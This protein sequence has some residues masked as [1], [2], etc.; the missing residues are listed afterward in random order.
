MGFVSRVAAGDYNHVRQP[1]VDNIVDST[2]SVER[3]VVNDLIKSTKLPDPLEPKSDFLPEKIAVVISWCMSM[4]SN[5]RQF[6][7][8]CCACLA[9]SQKEIPIKTKNDKLTHN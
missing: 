8:S 2:D 7:E 5:P 4:Y 3:S 1:D 9:P 6:Y